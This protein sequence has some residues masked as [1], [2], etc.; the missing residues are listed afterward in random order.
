MRLNNA[1]HLAYCTNIHRGETWEETFSALKTHTLGV[2]DRVS[3]ADP[4]A[5]GLRLSQR[6]ASELSTGKNLTDFRRWLEANR[7]Y[8]FTINGFP[9]GQ[10]HGTRVKEQVYAPDWTTLERLSY[11]NLLFDLVAELVPAGVEGSVSTLPGSFKPFITELAQRKRIISHLWACVEHIERLEQRTGKRF[12]LGLE[13]EPLGLFEN[14][15]ETLA[16][17]DEVR[18]ARPG[19]GRWQERLG[20]NYDACHFAIQFEEAGDALSRLRAAGLRISKLHLSSAL[21]LQPSAVVRERLRGFVEP[22]Y[23]HQVIAR[24][25]DG[26][27]TRFVDLPEALDAA[28]QQDFLSAPASDEWRV[29]FH[30]PLHWSGDGIFQNTRGHLEQVFAELHRD[31]SL[32]RHLEIETYTWEV[33]PGALRAR[34][35]VD[36]IAA[37]YAWCRQELT[38]PAPVGTESAQ[39]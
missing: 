25:V 34:S 21:R 11:T 18:A 22:T 26:R 3:P 30:V 17:F 5:I 24:G 10:F 29:H 35:V 38:R 31:P 6:A 2:R 19:D 16:F 32:C 36:Q 20:V 13:P 7:C 8:V 9:Y 33:M 12:H 37:E 15:S 14:T 28:A 1:W 4:F 27:L 23:L 39:P